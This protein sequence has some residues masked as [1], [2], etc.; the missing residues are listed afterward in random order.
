MLFMCV[1]NYTM[2]F[3][4]LNLDPKML[5]GSQNKNLLPDVRLCDYFD[6]TENT[7]ILCLMTL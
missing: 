2:T 7:P 1:L 4:Y 5:K 6:K 3:Y